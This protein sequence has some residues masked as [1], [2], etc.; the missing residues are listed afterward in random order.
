MFESY[1]RIGALVLYVNTHT[2][3]HFMCAHIYYVTS[4]CQQRKKVRL[5]L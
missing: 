5:G 2:H 1:N 3:T 4:Y